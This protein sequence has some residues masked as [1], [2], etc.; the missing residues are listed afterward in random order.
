MQTIIAGRVETQ[1]RAEQLIATL[2]KNGV[3]LVD[4][5]AFYVNPPGMHGQ[6]PLGGDADASK[7]AKKADEGQAKGVALGAAA[8]LAA[9]GVAA[10]AVPP[11][12]PVL[13]AALT[14][15]GA[16]VGGMA[17]ALASTRDPAE[18]KPPG[19]EEADET[20]PP[21]STDVRRG[22]MMLAVRV[23]EQSEKTVVDTMQAAGV[24]DIERAQ[25]EWSDGQ[26]VDFNPTSAPHKIKDDVSA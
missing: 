12:A 26:W 14:G 19:S 16:H 23:T 18:Q 1:D 20:G 21:Q 24:Q 6:F 3:A 8:G 7:G 11:L 22:G 10:V 25:G 17:G 9:G 2:R 5:Q 15:V 13:A 4:M